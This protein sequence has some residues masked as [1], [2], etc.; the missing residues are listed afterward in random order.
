MIRYL[1][2]HEL[3]K[4]QWDN[5]INHATNGIIYAQSWYLDTVCNG[6]EALVND[7]YS[8]VMPLTRRRKYGMNY[9]FPPYF[10]QQLGVF[11]LSTFTE[12]D[13]AQ[14]VAAIPT[15]YRFIEINLHYSNSW[16]P[17][18]FTAQSNSDFILKLGTPYKQIRGNYS[19][20]HHRNCNKASKNDLSLFKS[21]KV[22]KIIE[23]FR[24]NRGSQ[25][26]N[27][28]QIHYEVFNNLT[29]EAA[30]RGL[31]K[32]WSVSDSYGIPCAGA[33]FFRSGNSW[34]FIFSAITQTGRNLSAM[35][36]LIDSF[37]QEHC[38]EFD[39][40]DF[41]GSNNPDLARFYKGFG[42]TEFVYLQI[43]KNNLPPPW[44]W[45][46]K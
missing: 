32:I 25:I 31:T 37:I 35:H 12:K 14:F 4:A 45:F 10:S 40:L 26:C 43:K 18:N 44:S 19:E 6:W 2:N 28:K 16:C 11:S 39:S 38:N 5:C 42:S 27:L 34:I 3:D 46:K 29:A 41:E 22:S 33:V 13:F 21:E 1:R 23:M 17:E 7:D 24:Q 36:F 8:M 20:N 15:K 9:L 30:K